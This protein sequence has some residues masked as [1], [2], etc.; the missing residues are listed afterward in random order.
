MGGLELAIAQ[1][2]KWPALVGG[3]LVLV[4]L[5]VWWYRRAI[6]GQAKAEEQAK[7]SR[8]GA[9]RVQDGLDAMRDAPTEPVDVLADMDDE[10]HNNRK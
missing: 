2:L 3:A 4:G 6:A 1:L 5:L 8:K 9:E 10:L 7:A